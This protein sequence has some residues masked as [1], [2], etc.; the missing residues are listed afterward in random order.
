MSIYYNS[1]DPSYLT[2]QLANETFAIH[3]SSVIKILEM[4]K[5]TEIPRTPSFMKGVINLRG[6]VLPV[7][8]TREKFGMKAAA[9]GPRTCILVLKVFSENETLQ[10]GAIVDAVLDVVR[11]PDDQIKKAPTFGSRYPS[12][13]VAGVMKTEED[14]IIILNV[15]HVFSTD[16]IISMNENIQSQTEN[17][18]SSDQTKTKE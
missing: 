15:D 10:I 2:F 9:Y 11:H 16:E 7:I 1:S 18:S 8:D 12:E 3:V 4:Q 6:D 17:I 14:F 13:V 5:I